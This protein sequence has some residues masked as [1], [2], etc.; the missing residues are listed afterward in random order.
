MWLW[1]TEPTG[2]GHTEGAFFT[3]GAFL[4]LPVRGT[5]AAALA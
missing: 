1:T 2:P 4:A 3:E 5:M